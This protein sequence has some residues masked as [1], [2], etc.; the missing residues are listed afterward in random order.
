MRVWEKLWISCSFRYLNCYT[1]V[2]R[3]CLTPLCELDG[4]LPSAVVIL[5]VA[6]IVRQVG[7]LHLFNHQGD[8][9]LPLPEVLADCSRTWRGST[10]A[11][12]RLAVIRA[13][14]YTFIVT[15]WLPMSARESFWIRAEWGT[16]QGMTWMG[17]D[18]QG[19]TKEALESEYRSIQPCKAVTE[20]PLD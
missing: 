14:H 4:R 3:Q 10:C 1:L 15:R 5:H 7:L 13:H 19:V 12:R 20:A 17:Y 2:N 9:H 8:R 16:L 11:Q 18:M 6:G